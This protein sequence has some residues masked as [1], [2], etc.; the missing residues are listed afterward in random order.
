MPK[1][2]LEANAQAPQTVTE[3]E[4]LNLVRQRLS[5][6]IDT[7]KQIRDATTMTNAQMLTAVRLLARNQ[8]NI[9]R[10]MTKQF[11]DE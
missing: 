2:I 10:F 9:M 8:L 3:L 11:P 6:N 5:N 4:Q 1:S 7:L